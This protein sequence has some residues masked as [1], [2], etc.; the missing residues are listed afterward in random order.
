MSVKLALFVFREK[1][2]TILSGLLARAAETDQAGSNQTVMIGSETAGPAGQTNSHLSSL[3]RAKKSAG[4]GS[5]PLP[6]G[7]QCK[8]IKQVRLVSVSC[9]AL[10]F[11]K[12]KHEIEIAGR[13]PRPYVGTV[14]TVGTV[15]V[16]MILTQMKYCPPGWP[17]PGPDTTRDSS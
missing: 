9:S 13:V 8:R 14:G 11:I 1:P 3:V 2:A 4:V 7:L 15:L 10:T 5:D 17:E 12:L 6:C 16:V